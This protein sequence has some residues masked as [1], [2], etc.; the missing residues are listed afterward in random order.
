VIVAEADE[1][2]WIVVS[3]RKFKV[4]I[5]FPFFIVQVGFSEVTPDESAGLW[6]VQVAEQ[7]RVSQ[8]L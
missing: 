4:A 3:L 8:N 6:S 5:P 1:S 7:K 2:P